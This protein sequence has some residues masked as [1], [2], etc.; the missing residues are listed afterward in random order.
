MGEKHRD[1]GGLGKLIRGWG[2]L[3]IYSGFRHTLRHFAH[4]IFPAFNRRTDGGTRNRGYEER[5]HIL[6]LGQGQGPKAEKLVTLARENGDWVTHAASTALKGGE[7][8]CLS[9]SQ[10]ILVADAMHRAL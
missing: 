9:G 8:L 2:I 3:F 4:S 6:S 10:T 1:F 7:A 5:L